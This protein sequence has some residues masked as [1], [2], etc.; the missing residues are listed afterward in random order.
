MAAHYCTQCRTREVRQGASG[1]E[2]CSGQFPFQ[3]CCICAAAGGWKGWK[4][5]PSPPSFPRCL[6]T[7]RTAIPA[8]AWYAGERLLAVQGHRWRRRQG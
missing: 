4:V 8:V 1:P 7:D 5:M 3:C 2:L 6:P